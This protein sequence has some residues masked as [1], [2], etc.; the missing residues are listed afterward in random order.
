[1]A[2]KH[3]GKVIPKITILLACNF[4][5]PIA[6]RIDFLCVKSRVSCSNRTDGGREPTCSGAG[7]SHWQVSGVGEFKTIHTSLHCPS[8]PGDKNGIW[9]R[10]SSGRVSGSNPQLRHNP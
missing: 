2:G 1:M 5:H 6:H 8:F 4:S 7:D 9:F 3:R 10:I